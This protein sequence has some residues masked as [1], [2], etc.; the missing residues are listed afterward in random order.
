MSGIPRE[1]ILKE[2]ESCLQQVDQWAKG[3]IINYRFSWEYSMAAEALIEL[4]EAHDCGSIGGFGEGQPSTINGR[5]L[6]LKDR[7]DWIKN[8]TVK[9]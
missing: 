3:L 4:I 1:T 9:E 5:K 6:S 8:K 7:Y 2:I